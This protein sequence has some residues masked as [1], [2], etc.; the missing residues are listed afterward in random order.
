MAQKSKPFNRWLVVVGA[1]LIQLA[2]GA[3]YAWSVFTARL[4][5]PNGPYAFT[6]TETAWVFSAGLATFAIVMVLAGRWLPR[7]GPRALAMAGGLLLGA[8]YVLGGL[9][10][11]TFWVQLLSIG[12]LGDSGYAPTANFEAWLEQLV[13]MPAGVLP[14]RRGDLQALAAP[15]AAVD[16][17]EVVGEAAE[18]VPAR[19]VEG[20]ERA[21]T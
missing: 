1:V 18:V 4:T 11:N 2:L 19:A 14:E 10:G 3:I 15:D 20:L 16:H 8:G 13:E 5:D 21:I 17:L 9:L 7:V 12:I 6:A